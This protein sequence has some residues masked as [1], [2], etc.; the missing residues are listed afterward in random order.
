MVLQ[1]HVLDLIHVFAQNEGVQREPL[2]KR[3]LLPSDISFFLRRIRQFPVSLPA[4]RGP[5]GSRSFPPSFR[6]SGHPLE[7][8]PV[9]KT[10]PP[11]QE[12]ES[13]NE[14][15][16]QTPLFHGHEYGTCLLYAK[17]SQPKK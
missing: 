2:G 4:G 13:S 1:I 17:P 10:A 15:L 8:R 9:S 16:L 7:T 12:N 11:T 14:F 3:S 5:V 6:S